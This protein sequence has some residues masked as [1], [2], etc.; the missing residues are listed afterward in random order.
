MPMD[1]N[2]CLYYQIVL[3]RV[4]KL[5]NHALMGIL[6]FSMVTQNWKEHFTFVQ[7]MHG[8]QSAIVSGIMKTQM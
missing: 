7:I 5:H 4:L 6:G 1:F 8:Q 2:K 3:Q